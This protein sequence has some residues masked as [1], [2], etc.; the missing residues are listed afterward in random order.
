LLTITGTDF[1]SGAT[2]SVDGAA[3][4]VTVTASTSIT[5]TTPA[6]AA[7]TVDVVVTNP[8]GLSGRLAGAYTYTCP[9]V[10]PT[11]LRTS[12]STIGGNLLLFVLWDAVPNATSFVFEMGTAPGATTFTRDVTLNASG[13]GGGSIIVGAGTNAFTFVRG[14]SYFIRV[15]AKSACGTG[16]ASV[17]LQRDYT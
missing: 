4:S 10:A 15:R 16:P 17:E 9:L 5:A 12:S 14:T 1:Q 7:G 8:N 13:N 3:T 6:H 11:G 2:V